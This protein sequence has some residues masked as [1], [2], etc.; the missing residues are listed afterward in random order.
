MDEN[1]RLVDI[2]PDGCLLYFPMRGL[3]TPLHPTGWLMHFVNTHI[4]LVSLSTL[5]LE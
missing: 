4:V 2:T 3:S 1:W 5:P